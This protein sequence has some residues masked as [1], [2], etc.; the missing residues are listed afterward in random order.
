MS[1]EFI[2]KIVYEIISDSF[3]HSIPI[4]YQNN[5]YIKVLFNSIQ[6]KQ[7][8]T[9]LQGGNNLC[10]FY[11]LFNLIHF[12]K[13]IKSNESP[14]YLQSMTSR[15][16]FWKFHKKTL[17]KLLT[18]LQIEPSGQK[19]LLSNGPLERYQFNYLSKHK[20]LFKSS[21][22]LSIDLITF[23]Y[24]FGLFHCT[25]KEDVKQNQMLINKFI[26]QSNDNKRSFL[27]VLMGIVNHWNILVVEKKPK[28]NRE[29]IFHFIDS[30]NINVL[31]IEE[32]AI[33]IYSKNMI[34]YLTAFNR[35]PSEWWMKCFG[36]WIKDMHK[37]M[38]LIIDLIQGKTNLFDIY[39]IDTIGLMIKS[40]EE[41][42]SISL[43]NGDIDEDNNDK[44]II[45]EDRLITIFKWM[46][47]EYH[48]TVANEELIQGI[49]VFEYN[50]KIKY[51]ALYHNFIQWL[52]LIE[53]A[54]K[55]NLINANNIK[56]KK[57]ESE[58][59][60]SNELAFKY[61]Q[62]IYALYKLLKLS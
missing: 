55:E 13:Y 60:E 36:Q 8:K 22:D 51:I 41:F 52:K 43:S 9:L 48:P 33:D 62:I 7:Y 46:K 15:W 4:N 3:T 14:K 45:K 6:I 34:A 12:I 10:G 54:I 1:F 57:N 2:K 37:G 20:N 24:G 61:K 32:D 49:E 16:K 19:S 31:S 11:S 59:K 27:I 25:N 26:S 39:F 42:N 5:N 28:C 58:V 56:E 50:D 38:K 35:V 29:Y 21:S 47:E 30:R 40:F 18:E 23:F 44:E 53:K 17:N